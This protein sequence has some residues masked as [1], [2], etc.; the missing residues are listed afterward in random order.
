MSAFSD[1]LDRRRIMSQISRTYL[2]HSAAKIYCEFTR[3]LYK[4]W[5]SGPQ[6]PFGGAISVIDFTRFQK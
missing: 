3:I 2:A 4:G 5:D 6:R 1:S